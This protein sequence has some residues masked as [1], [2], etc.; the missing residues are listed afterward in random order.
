[1][2]R[3]CHG[4]VPRYSRACPLECE[5]PIERCE[6][7]WWRPCHDR[8]CSDGVCS[9]GSCVGCTPG[10]LA[11]SGQTI[12]LCASDGSGYGPFGE[13]G[14]NKHCVAGQCQDCYPGTRR[15]T[16]VVAEVCNVEGTWTTDIDC[17]AIGKSCTYGFCVSPCFDDFKSQTNVGCD[18]WAVDLDNHWNAQDSPFAVIVANLSDSV[19]TVQVTVRDGLESETSVVHE[20]VLPAGELKPLLLPSRQP[21]GAGLSWATYRVQASTPIIAYQFNPLDN[22]GVFSNDASLLLPLTALGTE[23]FV[24]SAAQFMG[25]GPVSG[26]AIPYRGTATVVG[27]LPNTQIQIRP[28]TKTLAGEGLPE[29]FP[30]QAYS[31]QLQPYQVL[32][33]KTDE[34][35][36]DLTGTEILSSGPVAVFGGH[37]SSSTS[38]KCCTDHVEHQLFPTSTWGKTHIAAKSPPRNLESD[39]WKIVASQDDTLVDCSP[40][41]GPQ[42]INRGEM[43]A[44][45]S[46]QSFVIT[47]TKPVM[48]SQ[49]L[50]SS[51]EILAKP[52][53]DPCENHTDCHPGYSC[54]YTDFDTLACFPPSC[55]GPEDDSCISGHRCTC[56]DPVHCACQ[57]IGDPAL[58]LLPPVEQFRKSYAF[59]TPDSYVEDHANVVAPVGAAVTLDGSPIP[60][61]SFQP[62]GE[63][64]FAVARVTLTDGNHVVSSTVPVGVTIYGYDKDVSYGYAAGLNLAK[65]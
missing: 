58:I 65:P 33:I 29:M 61:E 56:F 8:D 53:L 11:C 44:L 52:Q 36:G 47:A 54:K 1:T 63:S 40:I 2:G 16:G 18:Y 27:T 55:D 51:Q 32:T 35:G 9:N 50:A 38:G 26:E 49:T 25:S 5:R 17:G 4:Q 21:D 41:A 60:P 22:V 13:C 37:E 14:A 24:M 19:A 64:G 10:K 34:D 23:H 45:Q 20:T 6:G 15:C 57:A 48:V 43:I 62:I 39:Y 28:T 59:L 46:D 30:G 7:S 12:L 31:L 42:T 3:G